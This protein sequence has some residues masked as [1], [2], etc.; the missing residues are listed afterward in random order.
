MAFTSFSFTVIDYISPF[1]ENKSPYPNEPNLG[2]N[3]LIEFDLLDDVSGV[4]LSNTTISL[5]GDSV[6]NGTTFLYPFN[7]ASS[8]VSSTVVDGYDGYHFVID[9]VSEFPGSEMF[10]ISVSSVD[11]KSNILNESWQFYTRT[12]ISNV[13]NGPYEITL[14]VTF[15]ENMS[16]GLSNPANYQFSGDMYARLVDIISQKKVR[17][18]VELF[19]G[20]NAFTLITNDN[21]TD[22]YGSSVADSYSILPFQSTA[23]ISNTNGR[24]RT[25]RE[26]LLSAQDDK[27]VYIAGTK[28][29]EVFD[30]SS[31]IIPPNRWAQIFD[32]YGINTMFV[33]NFGNAYVSDDIITAPYLSNRLPF[34]NG[35]ASPSDSILFSIRDVKT[36]VEIQS[37]VVYVNGILAFKGFEKGW[38]NNFSGQITVGY[39]RLN[40][41]LTSPN[42]FVAY[43][44]TS[45]RV[46]AADL[47]NNILDETYSFN[48]LPTTAGAFG[49]AAFGVSSFGG[50]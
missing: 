26:S 44:T 41:I 17:L 30:F 34:P 3:F 15:S 50:I 46:I 35:D 10:T 27:R 8:L 40:F 2:S 16:G 28:G 42:P 5:D 12:R 48:I 21:I 36:S 9:R 24:I 7:G 38:R 23:N 33:G 11:K 45:V 14:D 43:T 37:V 18:W 20:S 22:S 6:Y 13:Q 19:E 29:L 39:K 32:S 4:D 31:G 47:M 1:I 25:W 49:I